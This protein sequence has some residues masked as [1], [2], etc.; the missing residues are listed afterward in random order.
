MPLSTGSKSCLVYSP[1]DFEG[2]T[3]SHMNSRSEPRRIAFSAQHS[4]FQ[5]CWSSGNIKGHDVPRKMVEN[6]NNILGGTVVRN[7]QTKKSNKQSCS[8]SQVWPRR[9]F[10]GSNHSCPHNS[11]GDV[12]PPSSP[13]KS[14]K[15]LHRILPCR[16][17]SLLCHSSCCEF[18][19]Q[20]RDI[21]PGIPVVRLAE[22]NWWAQEVVLWWNRTSSF[23]KAS[24]SI[25]P[26]HSLAF[27]PSTERLTSPPS[28]RARN[29][30]APLQHSACLLSLARAPIS[31]IG[32]PSLLCRLPRPG[33]TC[34]FHATAVLLGP[35][36]RA[37]W[38]QRIER[39]Q[40]PAP[41]TGNPD[42]HLRTRIDPWSPHRRH[43]KS[44]TCRWRGWMDC[45]PINWG[46]LAPEIMAYSRLPWIIQKKTWHRESKN[47]YMKDSLMD[48]W[49]F[50]FSY[51]HEELQV[52]LFLCSVLS[53]HLSP[54]H[55]LLM[56]EA[57]PR[58]FTA[59][60]EYG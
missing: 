7:G 55:K 53:N 6:K 51:L 43:S 36:A 42:L 57:G 20:A 35:P 40:F 46:S 31:L 32:F 8:T 15:S 2:R 4:A 50:W 58:C 28:G 1:L 34:I 26:G 27:P 9:M 44:R 38:G 19:A 33:R 24:R 45:A 23:G 5:T 17:P 47:Q 21:L 56:A 25:L 22:W 48:F 3:L 52:F 16:P 18:H 41:Y 49:W 29:K 59:G 37:L 60:D 11:P 30:S 39:K 54:C 10:Y 12:T 14:S 13:P